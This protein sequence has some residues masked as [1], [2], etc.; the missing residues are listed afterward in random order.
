MAGPEHSKHLHLKMPREQQEGEMKLH[1]AY[2]DD[3]QLEVICAKTC[4]GW[5]EISDWHELEPEPG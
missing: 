5:L 4:L 1:N 3:L 2:S